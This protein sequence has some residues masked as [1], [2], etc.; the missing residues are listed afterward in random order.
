MLFEGPVAVVERGDGVEVRG[1]VALLRWVGAA[2]ARGLMCAGWRHRLPA[3]HHIAVRVG[4]ARGPVRA[5][6]LPDAGE[7]DRL[8]AAAARAD[9]V[10]SPSQ[11]D[12]YNSYAS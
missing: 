4:D 12:W 2:V 1:V 6:G 11:R 10:A 7:E 3:S 8:L 9:C 5:V